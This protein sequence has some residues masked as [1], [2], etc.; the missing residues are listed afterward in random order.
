[1]I[2]INPNTIP[3]ISI[4]YS[5][6]FLKLWILVD[7]LYILC[8]EL[9]KILRKEAPEIGSWQLENKGRTS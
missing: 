5:I 1:V 9:Q 6:R 2:L 4:D 7:L 3:L 8:F